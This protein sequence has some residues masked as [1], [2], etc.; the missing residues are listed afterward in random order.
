MRVQPV[1][2]Y[3][4]AV[5]RGVP[6][7]LPDAAELLAPVT[8]IDG[9][10]L[11]CLIDAATGMIVASIDD[12]ENPVLGAAAAGA[13]DIVNVLALMNAKMATGEALEDVMVTFGDTFYLIR[14]LRRDPEPRILLLLILDRLRTNLAMAHRSVRDYCASFA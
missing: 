6:V 10:R 9:F 14:P 2:D 4:A 13:A 11:A 7:I 12:Q 3:D 5:Y 1:F 8:G